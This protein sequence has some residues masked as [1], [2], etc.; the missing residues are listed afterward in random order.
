MA[1]PLARRYI[2]VAKG[3]GAKS[4]EWRV[5]HLERYIEIMVKIALHYDFNHGEE[6][7]FE[8]ML[9]RWEEEATNMQQRAM[10]SLSAY[11]DGG[12]IEEI[13]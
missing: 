10:E 3:A 2:D 4:R 6:L 9:R 11:L 7:T 5:Y 8:T 12:M 13:K 1:S